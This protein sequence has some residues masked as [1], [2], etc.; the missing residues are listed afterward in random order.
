VSQTIASAY[1]AALTALDETEPRNASQ[2]G[3]LSGLS[4]GVCQTRWVKIYGMPALVESG[5]AQRVRGSSP[6]SWLRTPLGTSTL[7]LHQETKP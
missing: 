2:I 5:L 4:Y 3:R 7:S 6:A 1:L